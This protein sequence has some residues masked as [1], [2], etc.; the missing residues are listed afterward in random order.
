M[1][2]LITIL[3]TVFLITSCDPCKRLV[4]KYN[5]L[6]NKQER[7]ADRL[8][9]EGCNFIP[10]KD[11][12]IVTTR[13]TVYETLDS[14]VNFYE[15]IEVHDTT[16]IPCPEKINV[17]KKVTKDKGVT[18]TTEIK[19]NVLEA[20]ASC[21]SLKEIIKTQQILITEVR[22]EKEKEIKLLRS[23]SDRWKI[24]AIIL[25]IMLTFLVAVGIFRLTR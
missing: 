12:E 7:I 16:E 6:E 4:K 22:N 8:E 24:T 20:S 13:D 19:D 11:I 17:P 2:K 14:I 18:L 3:I 9:V 23:E 10:L 15:F 25:G 1:N 5:K 21:D